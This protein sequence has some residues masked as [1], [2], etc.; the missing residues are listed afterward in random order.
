MSVNSGQVFLWEMIGDSW[1]GTYGSHVIK[2]SPVDGGQEVFSFP[3]LRSCERR[4]FR[5][6]DDIVRILSEISR[7]QLVSR[8]VKKYAGLR[9]IRQEPE[10]CVLSFVCASNTNIPMIRTMLRNLTRKYGERVV[11]DGK[12]F[13]TFPSAKK[14]HRATKPEICSCGLGYRVK[15]I[16]AVAESIIN[17]NLDFEALQKAKYEDAKK[18]LLKVYGIGNKI[19]DCVMLFSL[20]KLEAFPIDVWIARSLARHF[21]CLSDSKFT[22]KLSPHQYDVLSDTMRAY[23]GRYAGYAQQYLFYHMRQQAGRKW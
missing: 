5:L 8:L 14:I 6:D 20:E 7:D 19:A 15:A 2:I 10:Q 17:G 1:F 23:F 21:K 12:E 9:L 22:E 16:K 11:V 3:E 4:I 13:F 18:E